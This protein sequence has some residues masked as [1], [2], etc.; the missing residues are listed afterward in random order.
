MYMC[1]RREMQPNAKFII[2]LADPVRRHYSDYYFLNDNRKVSYYS[3]FVASP[4]QWKECYFS[5]KMFVFSVKM[6]FFSG[7]MA[8]L[9]YARVH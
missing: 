1:H 3:G 9:V 6:F 2:T 4:F 5:V 7:I 8:I